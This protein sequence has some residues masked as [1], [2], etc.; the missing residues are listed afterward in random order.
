MAI[1]VS[2]A[3]MQGSPSESQ[4]RSGAKIA[5]RQLICDWGDRWTLLGQ[6]Q[7]D[8]YENESGTG[9]I[10]TGATSAPVLGAN[11]GATTISTYEKALITANYSIVT[12]E[13]D[14]SG[15]NITESIEPNAEFLTVSPKRL[16]WTNATGDQVVDDEAPGK[17]LIGFDYVINKENLVEVPST[18]LT[19]INKVNAASISPTSEGLDHLIFPAETLLYQPPSI[20]RSFN[21]DGDAV[22][23]V[24]Y[25]LTYKP[26]IDVSGVKRGWNYYFRVKDGAGEEGNFDTMFNF[27]GNQYLAYKTGDFTTI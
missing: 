18:I 21:E 9:M 3:E 19:L 26:N 8:A 13:S 23:N 27:N 10:C 7:N 14:P 22:W 4:A 1:T 6:I 17:L 16:R 20:A 11:S 2:Y 24:S 15:V 25:R 12:F 5:T